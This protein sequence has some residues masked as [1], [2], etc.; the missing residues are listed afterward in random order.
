MP[1]SPHDAF[2]ERAQGGGFIDPHA[3][4]R[5]QDLIR[6]YPGQPSW[7]L[8]I[9]AHLISPDDAASILARLGEYFLLCSRC[10][11]RLKR[12][13]FLSLSQTDCPNCKVALVPCTRATWSFPVLDPDSIEKDPLVGSS[14][15]PYRIE[16]RIG[17][18]GMG[19]VY[20]AS[21]VDSS[22]TWAVKIL[23]PALLFG[24]EERYIL[25]F[26][27]QASRITRLRHPNIIHVHAVEE[28]MGAH[29]VVME[30][31]EAGSLLDRLRRERKLDPHD[32]LDIV[33][34]AAGALD[35]A[36][37]HK[38][39]HLDMKPA[40]ILFA[41]D[42]S[43]RLTDFSGITEKE[44]DDP[45]SRARR[46]GTPAFMSPEQAA[47]TAV[48]ARSDIYSLG[49]VWVTTLVGK[50]PYVGEPSDVVR[51][52]KALEICP[53]VLEAAEV[54]PKGEYNVL[55]CMCAK[56]PEDRYDTMKACLTDLRRLR[57]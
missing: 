42:G 40:N 22:R 36:H 31:L 51:R 16:E 30:Y 11:L 8:A 45:T 29:L 28:H 14:L 47:R 17:K 44:L 3:R 34:S 32:A 38:V 43:I 24:A 56:K 23:S 7:Q 4:S 25:T 41:A 54:L 13:R 49:L 46:W 12:G 21:E 57:P 39:L 9:L 6:R 10:G 26:L 48:D 18:G 33:I 5:L 35:F 1:S 27:N 19:N 37:R 20:R 50:K 55:A 2:L 52:Q 15:G 53:L